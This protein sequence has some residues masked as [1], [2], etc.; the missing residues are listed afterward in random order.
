[1]ASDPSRELVQPI[2]PW[3]WATK[4]LKQFWSWHLCTVS[5]QRTIVSYRQ[6]TSVQFQSWTW[7]KVGQVAQVIDKTELMALLWLCLSNTP[8][9]KRC[10][11]LNNGQLRL[12]WSWRHSG[13]LSPAPFIAAMVMAIRTLRALALWNTI[14]YSMVVDQSDYSISTILYNSKYYVYMYFHYWIIMSWLMQHNLD[15]LYWLNNNVQVGATWSH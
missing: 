2:A 1:M 12:T 11:L 6:I 13:L 14:N 15:I 5:L 4:W 7:H 8:V 9:E 10:L 3:Q